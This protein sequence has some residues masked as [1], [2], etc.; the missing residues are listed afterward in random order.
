M[1]FTM[2]KSKTN[3]LRNP[4]FLVLL[5]LLTLSSSSIAMTGDSL[6]YLTTKDTVFLQAGTNG[7]KIFKH[8]FEEGQT[9]YSLAQFY[10]LSVQ[11]LYY[12]N[13]YLK[14]RSVAINDVIKIP[15]ANR[16]VIRYKEDDFKE[17]EHVPIYYIVSNGETLFRIA[18]KYFRMDVEFLKKRNA[19]KSERLVIGQR[20][21]IGW[22]NLNGFKVE[23]LEQLQFSNPLLRQNYQLRKQYLARG[24]GRRERQ[25]R[26]LALRSGYGKMKK[27]FVALHS[28][29][30]MNS[31]ILV[32]NPSTK[33]S[34]YL[35]VI[36][37]VPVSYE[38]DKRGA[39]VV[40]PN[41]MAKILGVVD[42]RFFAIVKY[43]R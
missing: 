2:N 15:V 41:E 11:D 7:E 22:I 31:I 26:G 3:M 4:T 43:H 6:H 37:R 24:N 27:G 13:S 25:H 39:L 23:E 38:D 5:F 32:T 10:G 9:L 14:R 34:V 8:T 36:G 18:K 28:S 1:F 35:K 17:K 30:P 12:Y 40:V 20:L 19:L 29:A 21:H 33:R 42:P 16:L